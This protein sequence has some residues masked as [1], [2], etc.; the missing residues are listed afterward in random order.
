MTIWVYSLLVL[1]LQEGVSALQCAQC[2]SELSPRCK[3]NPGSPQECQGD[4]KYCITIREYL[5][6]DSRSIFDEDGGHVPPTEDEDDDSFFTR[7]S[8]VFMARSCVKFF[9][10]N[11]CDEG[12]KEGQL[13]TICK[14]YCRTDGCNHAASAESHMAQ[15]LFVLISMIWVWKQ[16]NVQHWTV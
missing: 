15:L 6:N 4:M 5:R 12:V 14:E 7:R 2:T 8:L 9:G 3:E 10:G 11:N 1:I 13:R 16:K